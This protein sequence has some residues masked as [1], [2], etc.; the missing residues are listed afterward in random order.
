MR[1]SLPDS[2]CRYSKSYA[3]SAGYYLT[4]RACSQANK[5]Q[6]IIEKN[7]RFSKF[8]TFINTSGQFKSLLLKN[9]LVVSNRGPKKKFG[10]K[11]FWKCF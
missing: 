5:M 2:R 9:A 6:F 8:I 1:I 10:V 3:I 4:L 11:H 7:N